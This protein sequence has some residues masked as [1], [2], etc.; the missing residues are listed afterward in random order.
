M[1]ITGPAFLYEEESCWPNNEVESA[2][3][4]QDEVKPCL[5][6]TNNNTV[7]Q[8]SRFSSYTKLK[9]CVACVHRFIKRIHSTDDLRDDEVTSEDIIICR[10][11]QSECYQNEL[12]YLQK[13]QAVTKSR[14]IHS[15]VPYLDERLD[16]A[17]F[18]CKKTNYFTSKA[19]CFGTYNEALS[20]KKSS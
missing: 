10:L 7:I 4:L 18:E 2:D 19:L 20:Y 6:A 11:L 1:W 9:R 12:K 15:L 3:L 14:K 17:L 13:L 16:E 8:F 5:F